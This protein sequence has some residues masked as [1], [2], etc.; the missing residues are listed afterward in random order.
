MCAALL[1]AAYGADACVHPSPSGRSPAARSLSGALLLGLVVLTGWGLFMAVIGSALAAA[2]IV[3]G[4]AALLAAVSNT[5]RRVLGEPL[6]FSDFALLAAVFRHPQFYFSALAP[7]QRAG[8]LLL[9]PVLGP[10]IAW[11]IVN[12]S[13]AEREGGLA[14]VCGGFLMT[15]LALRLPAVAR[16]AQ[17]PDAE[18]DVRRHGL[19]AALLLHVVRWRQ[20][21]DPAALSPLA[22]AA[23]TQDDRLVVVVQC[24][25]FADPVALFGDAALGLPFLAAARRRARQWGDLGVTGFGAYT[26]RT[27]YG[28]I[29]GRSEAQL[30][31]RRFDPYLTALGETSYAL[32]MRLAPGGWRSLF[33]HP[34]DMRFYNRARILSAGGFAELV[35]EDRFAPPAPGEGRYVTDAAIA[36]VLLDLARDAAGP[37]LLYAVT[38]ENH[39]PWDAGG[40]DLREGYLR[41]VRKGDAMLGRLIER[42]DR[43]D[44]PVTLV[45]FGDHRPSI[46]GHVL[47]GSARETPYVILDLGRRALQLQPAAAPVGITPAELHQALFEVAITPA[48]SAH[49][50]GGRAESPA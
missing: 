37:T 34:H 20:T 10:P 6:L 42:L 35:G 8:L 16:L 45:F 11:L 22:P 29:F 1:A 49:A 46:P 39:G 2:L 50:A 26:M 9:A 40:G 4:L 17:V 41:L 48:A 7:W 38:I 31:F 28:V 19:L 33:V 36:D 21:R 23:F 5:K 44:R 18:A 47:P 12:G 30:G 13:L 14:L 32:P 43:L 27:E 25:S 24:E 3:G 15:G